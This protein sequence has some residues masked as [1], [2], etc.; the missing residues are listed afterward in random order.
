MR[1]CK[2]DSSNLNTVV[3]TKMDLSRVFSLSSLVACSWCVLYQEIYG[4]CSTF[5]RSWGIQLL[6]MCVY[7]LRTDK[8]FSCCVYECCE[9]SNYFPYTY[10]TIKC[11]YVER[12]VIVSCLRARAL[13]LLRV[14]LIHCLRAYVEEPFILVSKEPWSCVACVRAFVYVFNLSFLD[15]TLTFFLGKIQYHL[16]CVIRTYIFSC[17]YLSFILFN[18]ERSDW[19]YVG[20]YVTVC[21]CKCV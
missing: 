14:V 18:S 17:F 9:S 10:Y 2:C 19:V 7:V 8:K 4:S 21:I 5:I 12:T 1:V 15:C 13:C 20:V 16:I 3:H 11:H 6:C